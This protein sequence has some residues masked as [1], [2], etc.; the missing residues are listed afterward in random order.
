ML[1]HAEAIARA[2]PKRRVT[3]R[4]AIAEAGGVTEATFTDIETSAGA[5]A[6]EDLGLDEDSFA[7]IA[8][9]ALAAGIGVRGHVGRAESHLFG[10]A[11]LTAFAVS[12]LEDRFGGGG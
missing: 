1:H 11:E 6:Y 5:F 4:V 7:I 10:A 2:T 3:F 8:R 12:W 9:E